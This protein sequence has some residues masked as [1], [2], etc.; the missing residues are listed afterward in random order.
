MPFLRWLPRKVLY[1]ICIALTI[2]GVVYA[3][4]LISNYMPDQIT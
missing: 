3:L 4:T 1:I 2:G